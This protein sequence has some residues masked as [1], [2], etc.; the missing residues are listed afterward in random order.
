MNNLK[1]QK[2]IESDV[3]SINTSINN[4]N[5]LIGGGGLSTASNTLIG[6][7]NEIH[8]GYLPLTGGTLSGALTVPNIH[9]TGS[10]PITFLYNGTGVYTRSVIYCNSNGITIETPRVA[11]SSSA[12][13][14]PFYV[15]TRGGQYSPLYAGNIYQNGNQVSCMKF[16]RHS[17]AWSSSGVSAGSVKSVG[18]IMTRE[19]INSE[20]PSGYTYLGPLVEYSNFCDSWA[21]VLNYGPGYGI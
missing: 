9:I 4:I 19:A 5:T 21:A 20:T 16:I 2:V 10:T 12:N 18:R 3:T 7:I 14:M 13:I 17:Y 15:M 11:E 1:N 6:A 8:D